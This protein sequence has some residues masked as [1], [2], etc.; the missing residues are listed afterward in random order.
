MPLPG[1]QPGL[2]GALAELSPRKGMNDGQSERVD[3][4]PCALQT[5]PIKSGL[6]LLRS[7]SQSCSH[8]NQE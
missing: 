7:F 2:L 8:L 6:S 4:G 3:V 1:P 5:L